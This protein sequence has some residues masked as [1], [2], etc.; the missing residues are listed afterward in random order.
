LNRQQRERLF[1]SL[2]QRTFDVVVIGAGINGACI[3]HHLRQAGCRVLLTEQGD[4]SGGTSQAS[5]MMIWGG[6]LYLRHGDLP[7]VWR[8]VK[9]REDLIRRRSGWVRPQTFRYVPRRGGH[10]RLLVRAAL[11]FYWLLSGLRRRRPQ[12]L[13]RF[14]EQAFLNGLAGGEALTFE[15][16]FVQ[17]SDARY[18]LA[19]ILPPA[20]G[21]ESAALNYC[22]V[23][24]G[25]YVGDRPGYDLALTDTLLE[26]SVTS[27][28]RWVVNAAGVWAETL[29]QRFGLRAPYRHVFSKGVYVGLPRWPG[30]EVPL[31]LETRSLGDCMALTP[32]GPISLWGPTETVIDAPGQ[33]RQADPED[34]RFL[35]EE[36]NPYLARPV[37][38]RDIVCIRCGVRPLAVPR[39]RVR[40]DRSL[41]LSRRHH[42]YRHPGRPWVSI[43]GGK[44]TDAV[45]LARRV[46][47]QLRPFLPSVR[48]GGVV[49]L[50]QPPVV[51][52]VP[53][54]GLKEAVPDPAWCAAREQCWRLE[55]YLRRRTNIAQ[56]VPRGGLAA[57]DDHLPRLHAIADLL[58]EGDT[59]SARKDVEDYRARVRDEFDRVL[60]HC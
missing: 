46:T 5:G 22:R 7:S 35:L 57:H 21:E 13:T 55:D 34:V 37:T 56:W 33:G 36:I 27:R 48:P 3:Y 40:P 18:V 28:T 38:V 42:V 51:P 20:G 15:E 2:G 54:P 50:E 19:W 45:P 17:P 9:A 52:L 4:F 44:L 31:I 1:T 10:P 14:P 8:L 12:R 39:D 25:T 16:A 60:A 26:R 6:L 23:E 11:S 58:H 47:R 43:F 41:A 59:A 53:H 30:H 24:G 49:A 32:W 29:D